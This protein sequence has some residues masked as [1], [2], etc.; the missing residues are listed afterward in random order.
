M[1]VAQDQRPAA[2][3][4]RPG[5]ARRRPRGPLTPY[6]L[7]APALVVVGVFAAYPLVRS[8]WFA[9]N[10]ISPFSGERSFVGFENLAA[11][12]T[13]PGFSP[14][15]G[16][17]AMWVIGAVSLQL[18]FGLCLALLLDNRFPLRGVYR[19]L[20]MVPWATPSVLI[21]L[22]WKWILD[23]N[24]GIVNGALQGMGIID[25]PIEFLS[26]NATALPTLIMIDVWQGVPL[27]AVMILAA[28]QG[29]PGELKEA[30]GID[31]CGPFRVFRYVV[32]PVILPTILITVVL[33]LIWTANY[34]DL[35]FILT[36]GGPGNSSTT[37]A[38][39]SY[40]TAYKATDFGQ[41]ASYAVIQ[42]AILAI[43]VVL[44]LRMTNRKEAGR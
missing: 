16:R 37:L 23:P 14:T 39:E 40:L 41:G 15:L 7:L 28:L 17:T 21:A 8:I 26:T 22:M 9:F 2:S 3:G 18:I 12:V 44:Y 31:G 36:G 25:R 11:V 43:F 32:L 24:S 5:A 4:A 42:A 38:L 20:I 29:V 33:R 19:G 30:A 27:F 1:T 13:D 35:I 6:I 34:V 10:R